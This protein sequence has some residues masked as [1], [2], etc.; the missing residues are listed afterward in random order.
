MSK[1]QFISDKRLDLLNAGL[2]LFTQQGFFQTSVA[3]I[4]E[5]AKTP[6]GSFAYY[7]LTKK[8]YLL[9]T[10]NH[11]GNFFEIKLDKSLKRNDLKPLERI[12]H[13]M[14][15]ATYSM[16]KYKYT[17]GCLI[18]NLGQELASLDSDIRDALNLVLQRW[19]L[20]ISSCL[21]EIDTSHGG[22]DSIALGS[23][24]WSMWEGA[25]LL[26]KL[27][28]SRAPLDNTKKNYLLLAE[29]ILLINSI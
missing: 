22:K 27:T 25:V 6:K 16:D 3:D 17:R 19:T 24:F 2:V 7:F 29:K 20:K 23:L 15:Q 1:N 28:R 5:L 10:I 4:T 11:Y 26:S 14:G 9:Q 13:F 18:G 21:S 8:Q 12:E